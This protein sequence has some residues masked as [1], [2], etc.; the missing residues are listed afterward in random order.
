MHLISLELQTMKLA[1][2]R[3]ALHYG[4]IVHDIISMI[5]T[6]TQEQDI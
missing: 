5:Q 6:L 4:H 3:T 2:N 1:K